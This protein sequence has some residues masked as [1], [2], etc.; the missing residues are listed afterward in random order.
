[1]IATPLYF[2]LAQVFNNMLSVGIFPDVFKTAHICCIYK[3]SGV[4]S[5]KKNNQRPK[6]QLY[7]KL[8]NH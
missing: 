1:M 2:P 5:D 6:S 8:Q 7:P 4:M 3:R